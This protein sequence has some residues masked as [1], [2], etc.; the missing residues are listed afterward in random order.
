[1]LL[2]RRVRLVLGSL[3][4]GGGAERPPNKTR[5]SERDNSYGLMNARVVFY[6]ISIR[7]FFANNISGVRLPRH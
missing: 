1:M 5:E 6:G 3:L 7:T 2:E 4:G